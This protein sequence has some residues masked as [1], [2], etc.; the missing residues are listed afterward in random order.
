MQKLSFL[1]LLFFTITV[2]AQ[3]PHGENFDIDCEECHSTEK[4]DIDYSRFQ[5]NHS[6]TEIVTPQ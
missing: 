5:F 4:W 6:I 3:S 1:I 2:F